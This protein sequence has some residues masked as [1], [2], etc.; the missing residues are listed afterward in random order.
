LKEG[1]KVTGKGPGGFHNKRVSI[2]HPKLGP[3][4]GER[5]SLGAKGRVE[6]ASERTR[7]ES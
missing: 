5:V 7:L 2:N 3:R 1:G 4:K 6:T